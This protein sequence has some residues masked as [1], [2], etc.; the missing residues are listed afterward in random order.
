M[1]RHTIILSQ[2]LLS[3]LLLRRTGAEGARLDEVRGHVVDLEDVLAGAA[4]VLALVG[5]S[6]LSTQVP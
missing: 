4:V 6:L 3:H 1:N 2:V 5:S